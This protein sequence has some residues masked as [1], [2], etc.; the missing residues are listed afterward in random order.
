MNAMQMWIVSK[1]EDST[2]FGNMF[3]T[4]AKTCAVEGNE[5]TDMIPFLS[6]KTETRH[7]NGTL[8]SFL[9]ATSA[10]SVRLTVGFGSIS[11]WEVELLRCYCR[12]E[13]R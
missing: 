1:A 13:S 2:S 11:L 4:L 10:G 7:A 9:L 5:G 12:R 8:S 3:E 6:A